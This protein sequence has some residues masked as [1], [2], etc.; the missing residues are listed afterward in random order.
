MATVLFVGGGI[1][2]RPG[3]TRARELGHRVMVSDRN[4]HAPAGLL[5][6]R[7]LLADT[8]GPEETIAALEQAGERPDGVL[9]LG[10]DVP[11]TVARVAQHFD[12]PGISPRTAADA[13]DKFAMK[14]RLQA[15][16]VAVPWFSRVT[17]AAHLEQLIAQRGRDLVV[18]PV[19]SRGARGVIRLNADVDPRWAYTY[20]RDV[21]PTD[22]VMVEAYL[23]GPQVSTESLIIEGVAATPGFSDRNYELLETYAPFFIED[24]GD[25]PGHLSPTDRAAVIAEAEKAARAL[26]IHN[27]VAKGDMVLHRGKP[28]VI[29][30]AARLSGGYFCT[31]SI[32][33]C[34]GVDLVGA[35]IR[36]CLGDSVDPATLVP[37]HWR[38]VCQRYLFP[39][40]GKVQ[41][42]EGVDA[43]RAMPGVAYLEVRV[44]PG[45]VVGPM[46]NHPARAGVLMTTG[47][48]PETAR[49][50]AEAVAAR[51]RIATSTA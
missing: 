48:D 27:G 33:L 40:P 29:E 21:S 47:P 34:T 9:C 28:H 12:L 18:K 44:N 35:A 5:A 6:D 8:Y 25:L 14:Q 2:T 42:I 43:A 37:K 13:M 36:R 22:R 50:R 51:I 49:A 7:L 20:A 45:D 1:E 24:G 16:G 26:G 46:E 31:H 39:Q 10:S 38:A 15:G 4:P 30:I 19:D 32:P 41:S 11:L 17:S 23:D 3:V